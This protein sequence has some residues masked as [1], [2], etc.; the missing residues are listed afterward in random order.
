M[1][2]MVP[3]LAQASFVVQLWTV[4]RDTEARTTGR[5]LGLHERR[6]SL[7]VTIRPVSGLAQEP[8]LV[9]RSGT[10]VEGRGRHTNEALSDVGTFLSRVVLDADV[11]S[12]A[13]K[14]GVEAGGRVPGAVRGRGSWK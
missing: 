13:G 4:A 1:L 6:Q 8:H 14:T 10:A 11:P 9:C 5:S 3:L 7:T 12:S 2:G